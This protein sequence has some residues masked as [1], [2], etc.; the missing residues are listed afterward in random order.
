MGNGVVGLGLG[1]ESRG[2]GARLSAS[3][4]PAK[5]T[6]AAKLPEAPVPSS[7]PH[8]AALKLKQNPRHQ[9]LSMTPDP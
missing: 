4:H 2:A 7:E 1:A 9:A 8:K 5:T 6:Q 3:G